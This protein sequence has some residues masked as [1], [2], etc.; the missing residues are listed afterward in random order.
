METSMV[1]KD[2]CRHIGTTVTKK[3]V[4][5]RRTAYKI[6]FI[7]GILDGTETTVVIQQE[8]VPGGVTVEV[9][10]VPCV[11]VIMLAN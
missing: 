3:K 4:S 11:L 1:E 7:V 10:S 6:M 5:A 9:G 2:A 8:L